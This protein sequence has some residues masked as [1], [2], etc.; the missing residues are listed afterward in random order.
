MRKMKDGES[1]AERIEI[2]MEKIKKKHVSQL[3]DDCYYQEY[4]EKGVPFQVRRSNFLRDMPFEKKPEKDEEE[5]VGENDG[6]LKINRTMTIPDDELKKQQEAQDLEKAEATRDRTF[7]EFEKMYGDHL[8][9]KVD[10]ALRVAGR[11]VTAG[12]ED[13]GGSRTGSGA[14]AR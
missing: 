8:A 4:I 13:G 7:E 12:Y 3:I 11:P 2:Y 5:K 10:P 9:G 14:G 1:L 6:N